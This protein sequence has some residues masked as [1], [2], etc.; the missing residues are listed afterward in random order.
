MN[1]VNLISYVMKSD[2][3]YINE[4]SIRHFADKWLGPFKIVF[5]KDVNSV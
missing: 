3:Q 4:T 5:I 1:K 2:K